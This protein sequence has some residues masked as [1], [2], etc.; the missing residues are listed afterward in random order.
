MGRFWVT[1]S[2][3][4]QLTEGLEIIQGDLVAQ[5]MKENVLQSAADRDRFQPQ[6]RIVI[7]TFR[8]LRMSKRDTIRLYFAFNKDK[9]RSYPF[10]STKRSR[11]NHLEFLGLALKKLR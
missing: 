6:A 9:N 1:R 7:N 11:L 4:V 8:D 3:G 5:E 10:D 2:Q